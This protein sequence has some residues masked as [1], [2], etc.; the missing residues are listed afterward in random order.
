MNYKPYDCEICKCCKEKLNPLY[1]YS[2][3][4]CRK[5]QVETST[6]PRSLNLN[7]RIYKNLKSA[8][9]CDKCYPS[10]IKI[11]FFKIDS[12]IEKYEDKKYYRNEL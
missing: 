2:D 4:I 10:K 5:Y 1:D 9:Q 8:C 6:Y 3:V 12:L 11:F 7:D